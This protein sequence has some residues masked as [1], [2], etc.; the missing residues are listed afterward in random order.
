M[1]IP[2]FSRENFLKK[3]S[4]LIFI[5]LALSAFTH[6][7]NPT[8]FPYLYIDEDAY[9][10]RAMILLQGHGLKDKSYNYD[11]P[12]FGQ[13]FLATI[14]K[15][16]G[17]PDSLIPS[18]AE[19]DV[20]SIETIHSVPRILMGLLAVVDTFLV[21]KI[22][23]NR[24]NRRIALIASVLFAVM[25]ISWITRRILLDSILL[26]FLL[27]SILFAIYTKGSNNKIFINTPLVSGIFLGVSIFTKIPIITLI[28]FV[29]FFIYSNNNKSLKI[30][31]LW[32]V[33]VILI[34]LIWP[35][36]AL[37]VGE[38]NQW[39]H[40][41]YYETHRDQILAET[42]FESKPLLESINVFFK[43]DP[44][45]LVLGSAGLIYGAIKRDL[46][47]LLW[48]IPFTI[49]FYFI[50]FAQYFHVI[51]ILPPLCIGSAK[52]IN[53][54]SYIVIKKKIQQK[55]TK[56]F[57]TSARFSNSHI[58]DID[59]LLSVALPYIII[60]IIATFGIIS[61]IPL[62]TTN[63]N[64]THLKTIEF[65]ANYL[66]HNVTENSKNKITIISDIRYSWIFQHLLFPD[67]HYKR[68][69]DKEPVKTDKFV[70]IFDDE[71]DSTFKN[72]VETDGF[73]IGKKYVLDMQKIY[74]STVPIAE[75][76]AEQLGII[77]NR[78]PG[79]IEVRTNLP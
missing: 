1:I 74:N 58:K 62:I 56:Y 33:P 68:F 30:L 60:S 52:L 28:P 29:G 20:H 40:G 18:A 7:W 78:V 73:G 10:Q 31:A 79:L 75:F 67:Y 15:M 61:T 37:L 71:G 46:F 12:Y 14:F 77:K 47:L 19:G 72:F 5:P 13:I 3:S 54:L 69:W 53:D 25:P 22:S 55:I 21:Y 63:L 59:K 41:I 48:I 26:P 36:H 65:V 16:I 32:F 24:Y 38:F 70:M 8:G 45:L 27:L 66:S 43:I 6:I 34:P 44:V 64:S 57:S 35:I 17:Y 23:E 76:R 9:M 4:L 50:G 49:F 42:H 51:P 11:H 2:R 39:W